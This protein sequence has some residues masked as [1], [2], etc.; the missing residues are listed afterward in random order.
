MTL[1]SSPVEVKP[2]EAFRI[3]RETPGTRIVLAEK[4]LDY[5]PQRVF[6]NMAL[7]REVAFA[8]EADFGASNVAV[9]IKSYLGSPAKGRLRVKVT[10]AW[11][12]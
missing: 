5:A 7:D 4:P 8:A 12:S 3:A 11:R 1:E 10:G 6:T 2:C 9:T